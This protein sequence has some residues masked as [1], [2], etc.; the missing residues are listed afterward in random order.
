LQR[1]QGVPA[2]AREPCHGRSGCFSQ[3]QPQSSQRKQIVMFVT[4]KAAQNSIQVGDF[5][6]GDSTQLSSC[7]AISSLRAFLSKSSRSAPA[8]NV[9]AFSRK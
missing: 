2:Q 9:S 8:G 7:E 3:T 5:N 1:G 4:P 6:P